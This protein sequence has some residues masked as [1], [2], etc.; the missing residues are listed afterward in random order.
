M[1]DEAPYP[2]SLSNFQYLVGELYASTGTTTNL[3]TTSLNAPT[4]V[5]LNA[6]LQPAMSQ[7]TYAS[8]SGGGTYTGT[9]A[10]TA[11]VQF[12]EGTTVVGTGTLGGNGTI[13]SVTLAGVLPGDAHLHGTVSRRYDLYEPS[14]VRQR[15]GDRG[16]SADDDGRGS[17][18]QPGLRGADRDHGDGDAD[19][20]RDAH[21]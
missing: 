16:W 1:P 18:G 8:I 6:M 2:C 13:A 10:P 7:V 15:D 5:T 11:P 3:Q 20:H 12:L 21:G 9:P 4:S 17:F 19:G 14:D